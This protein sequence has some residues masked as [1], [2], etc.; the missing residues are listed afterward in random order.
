MGIAVF[1]PYGLMREESGILGLVSNYLRTNAWQVFDVRCNGV[2]SL[3][4]RDADT[5][6]K[7]EMSSCFGC[8]LEQARLEKWAGISCVELSKY[9]T[10]EDILES[11]RWLLSYENGSFEEAVYGQHNVFDLCRGSFHYRFGTEHPDLKNKNHEQAVRRM[12]VS[13]VRLLIATEKCNQQ[14][15]PEVALL[16]DGSDFLTAGYLAKSIEQDIRVATFRWDLAKRCVVVNTS[17]S[18]E[19][20]NCPLV[21]EDIT[22]MRS[23]VRTWPWEITQI[24]EELMVFLNLTSSQLE[25]PIACTATGK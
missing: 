6:W 13:T 2:F 20:Y 21:F 17:S 16:S 15:R 8:M 18:T 22:S 7:R 3:C 1:S 11:K 5:A 25:L 10:P 12:L 14:N 9:L 23:D 19:E 4:E 24:I